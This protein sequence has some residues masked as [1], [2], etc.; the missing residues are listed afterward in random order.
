MAV[1]PHKLNSFMGKA[2]GDMG[3]AMSTNIVLLGDKL[4]LY[5]AM[6]KEGPVTPRNSKGNKDNPRVR[7][8]VAGQTSHRWTLDL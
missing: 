6:A 1:N 2:V 5:N 8:W 7:R 4:G 3:P